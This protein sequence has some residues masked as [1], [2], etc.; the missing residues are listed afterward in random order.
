M[1]N[2]AAQVKAHTDAIARHEKKAAEHR[3][4]V[5]AYLARTA[6]G[7]TLAEIEWETVSR[8]A[9]RLMRRGRHLSSEPAAV[10]EWAAFQLR[11]AAARAALP[12]CEP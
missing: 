12:G 11:H 1:S 2:D 4:A 9:R 6:E 7:R 8:E 3:L 10:A 5:G